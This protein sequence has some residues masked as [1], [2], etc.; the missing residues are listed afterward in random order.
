MNLTP[1]KGARESV[2]IDFCSTGVHNVGTAHFQPVPGTV[3]QSRP[4]FPPAV[5]SLQLKFIT[6]QQ[7]HALDLLRYRKVDALVAVSQV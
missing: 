7:S 2:R 1:W 6:K 3:K 5:C 4:T